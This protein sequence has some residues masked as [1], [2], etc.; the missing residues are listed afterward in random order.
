MGCGDQGGRRRRVTRKTHKRAEDAR[1]RAGGAL[2]NVLIIFYANRYLTQRACEIARPL[3]RIKTFAKKFR[4]VIA[5]ELNFFH[6]NAAAHALC[7]FIPS[8]LPGLAIAALCILIARGNDA[9]N[10]GGMHVHALFHASLRQLLQG[11]P[12]SGAARHCA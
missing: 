1:E 7:F 12:C 11:P 5:P 4:N 2:V 10:W 8:S 6:S 3:H 9:A